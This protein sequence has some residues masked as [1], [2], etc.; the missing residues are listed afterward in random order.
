MLVL[1]PG[2]YGYRIR[3]AYTNPATLPIAVK[4]VEAQISSA[5]DT[6]DE[7]RPVTPVAMTA[8]NV[9][10]GDVD[11]GAA[12]DLRIRYVDEFGRTG[13]WAYVTNHTVVG[14]TTPP[15][16]IGQVTAFLRGQQVF[17]D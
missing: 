6:S 12:Y 8:G 17:L 4:Y 5:D 16:A 1:G 10:F 3:V 13:P 15:S 11:E 7:W 14:K 2:K 9:Y